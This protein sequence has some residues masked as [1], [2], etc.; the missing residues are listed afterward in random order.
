MEKDVR[1]WAFAEAS[2][3]ELTFCVR[4]LRRDSGATTVALKALIDATGLCG[5]YDF[6]HVPT[7]FRSKE[8]FGYSFINFVNP[9]AARRFQGAVA[10]GVLSRF[11]AGSGA[12]HATPS[13]RQGLAECLISWFRGHSRSVRSADVF[14]FVRPLHPTTPVNPHP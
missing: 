9:G 2:P 10:A 1:D 5:E 12:M 7:D 14:P 11:A 6:L 3:G 8:G 4:G 13:K